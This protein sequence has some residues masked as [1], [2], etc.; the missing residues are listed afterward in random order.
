MT[1]SNVSNCLLQWHRCWLTA[2][3]FRHSEHFVEQFFLLEFE[4]RSVRIVVIFLEV[5]AQIFGHTKKLDSKIRAGG[6]FSF[7]LTV[8]FRVFFTISFDPQPPQ[9]KPRCK[10]C[11]ISLVHIDFL[12]GHLEC[13]MSPV[14]LTE[15]LFFFSPLCVLSIL[16][17]TVLLFFHH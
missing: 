17:Q 11:E 7:F 10:S 9:H 13:A 1:H 5:C 2:S 15:P 16:F 3:N 12:N 14:A 4:A 8:L 6:W